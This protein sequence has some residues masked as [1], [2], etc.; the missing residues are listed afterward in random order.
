MIGQ[1]TLPAL[2]LSND[3]VVFYGVYIVICLSLENQIGNGL[4]LLLS[5]C[6]HKYSLPKAGAETA[7]GDVFLSGP[8][9]FGSTHN[10]SIITDLFQIARIFTEKNA[11]VLL[12]CRWGRAD[13]PK[14]SV[15]PGSECALFCAAADPVIQKGHLFRGVK[16][17]FPA[18]HHGQRG[19]DAGG[20]GRDCGPVCQ[21]I[22]FAV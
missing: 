7:T 10:G 2:Y 21:M 15:L 8:P 20:K 12:A 19:R 18:R 17:V 9:F 5:C 4:L 11:A 16:P 3:P 14:L 13:T 6:F 22:L 1:P